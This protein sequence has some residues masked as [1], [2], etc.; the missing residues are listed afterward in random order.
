MRAIWRND[1]QRFCAAH[2]LEVSM[3]RR[4][5]CWEN[6]VSMKVNALE[7]Q[8]DGRM[9]LQ[10]PEER[11]HPGQNLQLARGGQARCVDYIEVY[12]S[13]KRRHTYLDDVSPVELAAAS[14]GSCN[15]LQNPGRTNHFN[16]ESF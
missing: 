5:N 15:C 10:Q 14:I 16:L 4:G 8:F 1:W 9:L 7:L 6:K 12:Y 13:R 2:G 3:S 11:A